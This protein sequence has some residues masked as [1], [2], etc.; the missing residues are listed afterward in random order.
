VRCDTGDVNRRRY[1]HGDLRH[2]VLVAARAQIDRFG[3]E[4]FSLAQIA[5]DLS[6]S[7][8]APYHHFSSANALLDTVAE[9]AYGEWSDLMWQPLRPLTDDV[10]PNTDAVITAHLEACGAF[11]DYCVAHPALAR[12]SLVDHRPAADSAP[13]TSARNWIIASGRLLVA[14]GVIAPG[15]ES[16]VSAELYCVMRGAIAIAAEAPRLMDDIRQPRLID[17]MIL[18]VLAAHAPAAATWPND[19]AH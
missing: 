17:R 6:V 8:T 10:E 7:S 5:R 4:G 3:T 9:Q 13:V 16:L 1:H 19:R 15:T 12:L 18:L 14:G 11:V 2:A